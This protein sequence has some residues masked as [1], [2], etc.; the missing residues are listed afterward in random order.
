M[1]KELEMKCSHQNTGR[2]KENIE[3]FSSD[4]LNEMKALKKSKT[5]LE[6]KLRKYATYCQNLERDKDAI[7]ESLRAILPED[8]S[9]LVE[10]DVV[11]SVDDVI[12]RLRDAEDECEAVK[13][14]EERA[15]SYLMEADR[16]R[17]TNAALENGMAVTEEKISEL[18]QINEK[19]Q[20]DLRDAEDKIS[21]LRKEKESFKEL[22]V[23][24]KGNANDIEAENEGKIRFLTQENHKLYMDLKKLRQENQQLSLN[25]NQAQIGLNEDTTADL[26]G[27]SM[28][29]TVSSPMAK[30][31]A[32]EKENN[33]TTASKYARSPIARSSTKKIKKKTRISMTPKKLASIAGLGSGEAL[34]ADENNEESCTQS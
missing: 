31:L 4:N 13:N 17:E 16:L 19:C 24:A 11:S 34:K 2:N 12:Q 28:D 6:Q 25:L 32:A 1:K 26:K 33:P 15:T 3:S 20:V 23:T 5:V 27:I 22:A 14:S 10:E 7:V 9:S 18:M 30:L 21:A 8:R 29:I